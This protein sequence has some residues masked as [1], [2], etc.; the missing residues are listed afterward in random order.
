MQLQ[1]P[2]VGPYMIT[3]AHKYQAS[4]QLVLGDEDPDDPK[5]QGFVELPSSIEDPLNNQ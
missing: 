5:L 1:A 3:P 2:L 4:Y